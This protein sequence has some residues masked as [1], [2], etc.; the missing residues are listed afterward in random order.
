[1]TKQMTDKMRAD[2]AE[3]ARWSLEHLIKIT[4]SA[5]TKLEK[6]IEDRKKKGLGTIAAEVSIVFYNSK[7]EALQVA[8]E[9]VKQHNATI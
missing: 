9:A 3:H 2:G 7:I 1:M 5:V 8:L 6:E 4:R